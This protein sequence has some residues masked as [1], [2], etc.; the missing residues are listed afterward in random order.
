[1][2]YHDQADVVGEPHQRGS[3]GDGVRELI[4]K[5]VLLG[6]PGDR[7][8]RNAARHTPFSDTVIH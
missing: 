7:T 2:V 8:L 3:Q 5:N 1:M 4:V 6:W